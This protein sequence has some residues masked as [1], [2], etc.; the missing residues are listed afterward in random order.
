MAPPIF[1][2]LACGATTRSDKG[3]MSHLQQRDDCRDRLRQ[4]RQKARARTS[5]KRNEHPEDEPQ[6]P[7]ENQPFD[8]PPSPPV[9]N[10]PSRK[11]QRVYVEEEV[12]RDCLPGHR[13][14]E[15][16]P[17]AGKVFGQKKTTW[18]ARRE[19]DVEEGC[20]PWAPFKSKDEWSLAEW[21][22]TCG[23]S[24]KEMDKHLKLPTVSTFSFRNLQTSLI[25]SLLLI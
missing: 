6:P 8:A 18:E 19:A 10:G 1:R 16:H 11:R 17:T 21:L 23:I 9:D 7:L 13:I 3:L 25:L 2:C 22:M 15:T 14:T 24:Q 4:Q 5:T 20:E 12:D